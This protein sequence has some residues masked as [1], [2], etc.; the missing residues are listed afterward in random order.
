[1]SWLSRALNVFRASRVSDELDDEL[2]FH[3]ESRVR[4]LVARGMPA[5]EAEREAR[6]RLG[7]PIVL[8][9]RSLDV[10]LLAGLDAGINDLRTAV[11]KLRREGVVTAAAIGSLALAIGGCT[12]AFALVDALILRQLPVRDPA[13]LVSLTIFEGTDRERG[14]FNYPLYQSMS[15]A[16]HGRAELAAFGN[17]WPGMAVFDVA[18]GDE[19]VYRQ[20][21]SGNGLGMLGIT[22]AAGRLIVPSDDVPGSAHD[23]AVLSHAF[24]TSRFGADPR[25]IGRRF[26]LERKTY[27]IVGVARAGFTGI[28]P[29]ISTSLWI[30]LTSTPEQEALTSAG[31]HWFRVIGRLAAN[32]RA[33]ELQ[34]PLQAAL[35]TQRRE[36]AAGQPDVPRA[37]RQRFLGARLIVRSAASG[38]SGLRTDFERPLWILCAVVGLV[39]LLACSNLANLM[40]ARGAGREREM[41][42]RLSIGAGRGRLVQQM[43]LEAAAIA[44]AAAALGAAFARIAAPVIVA[45]L[46]PSDTPAYLDVRFDGRVLAFA[47]GLGALA[48]VAFGLVPALRASGTSPVDALKGSSGRHT[49]RAGLLRPLVS[50]Q[51]AFSLAVLF[52]AVLLLASFARLSSVAPGFDASN[53]TL[54]SADLTSPADGDRARDAARMLV[55]QV[56]ALP[57]VEAAGLSRWP[58]LGGSGW[59]GTVLVDG[60][61]PSDL[62]VTFVEVTP[63]FVGALRIRLLAGRD[64]IDAD[65]DPGSPSVLVNETFARVFLYGGPVLG[66]RFTRPERRSEREPDRQQPQQVVGIVA[67]A[68]YNDMKETPPPT[69]YMPLGVSPDRTD[70]GGTIAIRSAR[71]EAEVA[72]LVRNAAARMSPGMKVVEVTAQSTLIA[73]TMLR[74]RLLALLS[75]FFA[76]LSLALAAVGL[77][78]VLSYSVVQQTREIGIRVA[79]GAT[80]RAVVRGVV[81]GISVHVLLGMAV[82]LAVG[83]WLSQF[84]A[85]L[86]YEVKPL[87][88][89]SVGWPVALLAIV[90]LAAALLPARRAAGI[91]PMVALRDE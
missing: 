79:L 71:H 34:P 84:V 82:G 33:D 53:V 73:N 19:R 43:L 77:Y 20:F 31:W 14:S 83:L 65:F 12:A 74:E 13:S 76:V 3:I 72:E 60:R 55:D 11:R 54:V 2:E 50:T 44:A 16:A 22:P 69:I 63:G 91:D 6:R 66:R 48:T 59:D 67:D 70:R 45:L 56:R 21:V 1:M 87:D 90:A 61:R 15:G 30:P 78:G 46:A 18:A 32:H 89:A 40:L 35:M 24:W 23:V 4:D 26:T 8:R 85:K 58:L 47:A 75:G 52:L 81:R 57:G 88:A 51:I 10:K 29:G 39:L 17:Q 27:E 64:L 5:P 49:A 37:E 25:V 86:L 80:R 36:R 41:A 42:L 7:N 28:E 38:V 68:K 9:E 62:P